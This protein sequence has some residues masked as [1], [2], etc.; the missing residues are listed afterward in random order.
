MTALTAVTPFDL[1]VRVG[2]TTEAFGAHL[3]ITQKGIQGW[4]G[5]GV[6]VKSRSTPRLNRHG[7]FSEPGKRGARLVT[8]SG[9]YWADSVQEA[10]ALVDT[11]NAFLADGEEGRLTI[12]DPAFG[13][14]RWAFCTL[15]GTPEVDWDGDD[16]GTFSFDLKCA[17]PRKYGQPATG[18]V[19]GVAAPTGGLFMDPVFGS[20]ANPG[21]ADFGTG[22]TSGTITWTNTGTADVFPFFR[23]DGRADGFTIT[24]VETERRTV[25]NQLVP[26]GQYLELDAAVGTVM[27][28]GDVD[29]SDGLGIAQWAQIPGGA[30][31]TYMFE[32]PLSHDTAR[33]TMEVA[34][35]WW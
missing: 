20:S 6:P 28:N 9:V 25:F 2:D 21:V 19:T 12:D 22:G 10:A 3:Q 18:L 13:P 17:D 24:E 11:I 27:I 1:R 26:A 31:R 33:L 23:V 34:P 29:R 35:A 30:T 8:L 16:T 4:Y 7:E 32:S 5:G 15:S 14:P